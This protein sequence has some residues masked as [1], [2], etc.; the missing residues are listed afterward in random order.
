DAAGEVQAPRHAARVLSDGV[1]GAA[2]ETDQRERACDRRTG[3][4]PIETLERGEV[5]E[6]FPPGERR[7]DGH[8]RRDEAERPP[9]ASRAGREHVPGYLDVTR[10]LRQQRREDR[11]RGRLAGAV[12]AEQR[13]DLARRDLEAHAV[14][15]APRTIGLHHV[16]AEDGSAHRTTSLTSR[17]RP[18]NRTRTIC[19]ES[20]IS[21]TTHQRRSRSGRAAARARHSAMTSAG[22]KRTARTKPS[23][24]TIRSSTTPKTCAESG[25]RSIGLTMYTT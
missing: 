20:T 10:R 3:P 19:Q 7:V 12:R 5:G 4:A 14:E 21:P 1:V 17:Q 25:M 9:G 6:G 13:H 24:N 16:P 22:T 15:G 23:D 8:A 18:A 11:E 2:L